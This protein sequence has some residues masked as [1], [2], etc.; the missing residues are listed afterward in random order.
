MTESMVSAQTI[1]KKTKKLYIRK[2]IPN[3][4]IAYRHDAGG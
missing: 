1:E 2:S 4:I 3:D